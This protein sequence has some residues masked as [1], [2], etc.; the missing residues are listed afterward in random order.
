MKT[1][2]ADLDLKR[3]YSVFR[4]IPNLCSGGVCDCEVHAGE[5]QN[6]NAD[7]V[8]SDAIGHGLGP[9]LSGAEGVRCEGGEGGGVAG[10]VQAGDPEQVA[11]A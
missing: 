11:R 8:G 10:T 6:K 4:S 1:T 9:P 7:A 5:V 2:S 3:R